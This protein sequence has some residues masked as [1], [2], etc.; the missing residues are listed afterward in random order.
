M[1]SIG[2][3]RHIDRLGR[4]VLPME[5][6]KVF[7]IKQDDPLE[8]YVDEDK[9]ILKQYKPACIFCG[10][11]KEMV[12]YKGQNICKKCLEELKAQEE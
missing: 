2:V 3:V 4:I 6:R 12:S 8:I 9:I 1:K 11:A 7:G 5:L 10:N